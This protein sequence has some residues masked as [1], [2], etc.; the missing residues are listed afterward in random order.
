MTKRLSF[1]TN[2]LI[3]AIDATEGVKQPRAAVLIDQARLADG[4]LT[5]QVIG[6]LLN[7]GRKRPNL[8]TETTRAMAEELCISFPTRPT[9]VEALFRAFGRAER[10]RLQFWDSVIATICIDN[11]V[12]ILLSEDLQDGLNI[13]G[14]L[15]LNPFNPSNAAQIDAAF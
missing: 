3:Y 13:D 10:H 1:D 2:I 12:D 7:V 9:P 11:H 5:Q 8:S 6:E 14:L 15:V 4:L